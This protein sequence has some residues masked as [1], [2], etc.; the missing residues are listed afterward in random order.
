VSKLATALC[1]AGVQ[2]QSAAS[3]AG[4]KSPLKINLYQKITRGSL[5]L[6]VTHPV[7]DSRELREF[8]RQC[9]SGAPYFDSPGAAAAAG[10]PLTDAV[11]M[12]AAM[13]WKPRESSTEPPVRI[14]LPGTAPLAKLYEA[15]DRLQG[16]PVFESPTGSTERVAPQ[17]AQRTAKAGAAEPPVRGS[18]PAVRLTASGPSRPAAAKSAGSPPQAPVKARYRAAGSVG[19]PR[20]SRE[21]AAGRKS[22]VAK[23]ETASKAAARASKPPAAQPAGASNLEKKVRPAETAASVE[24]RTPPQDTS[25][26]DATKLPAGEVAGAEGGERMPGVEVEVAQEQGLEE[27]AARDSVERDS[28]E[29]SA[30]EDVLADSL[31]GDDRVHEVD[32]HSEDEL[33]RNKPSGVRH[34]ADEDYAETRHRDVD[35]LSE[36]VEDIDYGLIAVSDNRPSSPALHVGTHR[37][38]VDPDGEPDALPSSTNMVARLIE[39]ASAVLDDNDPLRMAGDHNDDILCAA[40]LSSRPVGTAAVDIEEEASS[41]RQTASEELAETEESEMRQEMSDDLVELETGAGESEV[42]DSLLCDLQQSPRPACPVADEPADESEDMTEPDLEPDEGAENAGCEFGGEPADDL[43]PSLSP[44]IQTTKF[45][46][47]DELDDEQQLEDIE[48]A[49]SEEW[50]TDPVHGET[51]RADSGVMPQGLPSPQQEAEWLEIEQEDAEAG[52]GFAGDETVDRGQSVRPVDDDNGVAMAPSPAFDNDDDD[53]DDENIEQGRDDLMTST[54]HRDLE[55]FDEIVRNDESSPNTGTSPV[56][57]HSAFEKMTEEPAEQS[58]L[59]AEVPHSVDDID[60]PP[61]DED[62]EE[63]IAGEAVQCDE[64]LE[65]VDTADF[66]DNLL[67]G[68]DEPLSSELHAE[69][70]TARAWEDIEAPCS[71]DEPHDT[72]QLPQAEEWPGPTVTGDVDD[73]TPEME[74]S[75][76]PLH[77]QFPAD[78]EPLEPQEEQTGD[79]PYAGALLPDDVDAPDDVPIS[80]VDHPAQESVPNDSE[81]PSFYYTEPQV[82]LTEDVDRESDAELASTSATDGAAAGSADDGQTDPTEESWSHA[83]DDEEPFDPLQSWGPPMGLPA[84]LGSDDAGKKRDGTGRAA[85][86]RGAQ[87]A[88]KGDA[89]KAAGSA[90]KT[91]GASRDLAAGQNGGRKPGKPAERLAAATGRSGVA[92]ADARK[93]RIPS[94]V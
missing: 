81:R 64:Q 3:P 23:N 94:G 42:D 57:R 41:D 9:A 89:R 28:L 59:Q 56:E 50:K 72:N 74:K 78:I 71:D 15:L 13:V 20:G 35:V 69:D 27:L 49:V 29:A 16:I 65:V 68:S 30:G 70:L 90:G 2:L 38:R 52:C 83:A 25:P 61:R 86:A 44:A 6:Y 66:C 87:A 7:E 80:P 18:R 1:D 63:E 58:D 36:G 82:Q 33:D 73:K 51:A 46:P 76:R 8:R 67:P 93:V 32:V 47:A 45:E 60:L 11:S 17:S 92:A 12:V 55:S 26:A 53:D 22:V 77:E 88:Q 84:P 91:T 40:A 19:S 37:E 5:D 85:V 54:Q 48:A 4:A 39:K 43:T 14:L 31:C 79:V 21:A 62:A 75:E 34:A 10:V 24:I